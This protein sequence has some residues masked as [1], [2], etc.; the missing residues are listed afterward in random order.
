M[1]A[2]GCGWTRNP[3]LGGAF[4]P[5]GTTLCGMRLL[6]VPILAAALHAGWIG[7]EMVS[8][9]THQDVEY[10]PALGAGRALV[11]A[12]A[13]ECENVFAAYAPSEP[14]PVQTVREELWAG[15]VV[16]GDGY[17]SLLYSA[18]CPGKT[19]DLVRQ[20]LDGRVVER[21]PLPVR[22]SPYPAKVV[23]G[24]TGRSPSRG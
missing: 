16:A 20:G 7:Q 3:P 24:R 21:V 5:S 4:G 11:G 10:R 8:T 17:A 9:L 23:A 12:Y 15:P 19:L 22:G 6:L 1:P 2:P 14:P 13:G 18:R